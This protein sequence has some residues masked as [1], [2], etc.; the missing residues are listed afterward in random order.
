MGAPILLSEHRMKKNDANHKPIREEDVPVTMNY[1]REFR[2]E[3][4]SR[5]S[6]QENEFNKKFDELMMAV[7][8][9]KLV[10][11]E[12]NLRNKQAY[13]STA[14]AYERLMLLESRIK[15]ECLKDNGA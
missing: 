2:A 15:A 5:L 8:S 14:F 6:R 10:C 7:H 12:Q 1:M 4:N 13:D 11:E 3:I 9:I